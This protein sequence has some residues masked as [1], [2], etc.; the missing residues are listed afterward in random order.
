MN[1]IHSASLAHDELSIDVDVTDAP[2]P[3]HRPDDTWQALG[4]AIGDARADEIVRASE[5]K[6]LVAP[7]IAAPP[8]R[9]VP[10]RTTP[11]S[12]RVP[13]S[14]Y[15][16]ELPSREPQALMSAQHPAFQWKDTADASLSLQVPVRKPRALRTARMVVAGVTA[17]GAVVCVLALVMS[18]LGTDDT[19]PSNA[20][21]ASQ[22]PPE[23]QTALPEQQAPRNDEVARDVTA[24]NTQSTS[25]TKNVMGST[26]APSSGTTA[27]ADHPGVSV[28]SL[29]LA[30]SRPSPRK[31]TKKR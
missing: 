20:V 4:R 17:V 19:A 25:W 27:G 14:L 13:E 16:V 8:A 23:A 18:R 29:P 22:P 21:A 12:T 2:P 11:P 31:P 26:A 9:H 10:T 30:G 15:P 5:R 1:Q 28:D 6:V 24:M 3:R 7:Y